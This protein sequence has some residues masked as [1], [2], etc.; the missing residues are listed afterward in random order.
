MIS[1]PI[2]R[3]GSLRDWSELIARWSLGACFI[4]MGLSKALLPV[5]FLKL[6]RQYELVDTPLLLNF[7][8]ATLPWFEIFCGLLLIAGIAVRGSALVLLGMLLPFTVVIV[9]RAK[10]LQTLHGIGFCAVKFDCGCGAG[11]VL[12]CRKLAENCLWILLAAWLLASRSRQLC[13]RHCLWSPAGADASNDA[14]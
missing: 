5:E 8:A 13:W 9:W 7:L 12:V 10:T 11:E 3:S 4:Y 1:S 2:L 6:V 14:A